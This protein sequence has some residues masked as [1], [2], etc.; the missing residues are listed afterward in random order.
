[1]LE[2][3]GAEKDNEKKDIGKKNNEKKDIETRQ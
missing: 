1:M 3:Y 2:N